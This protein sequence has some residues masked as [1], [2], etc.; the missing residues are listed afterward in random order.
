M[1]ILKVLQTAVWLSK[2]YLSVHSVFVFI[3]V[4][5]CSSMQICVLASDLLYLCLHFIRVIFCFFVNS[6]HLIIVYEFSWRT[7]HGKPFEFVQ[8][9]AGCEQSA[10]RF[11]VAGHY[12]LICS[13]IL[14][15]YQQVKSILGL[16]YT[17]ILKLELRQACSSRWAVGLSVSQRSCSNAGTEKMG[18]D[19]SEPL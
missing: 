18:R 19:G 13:E 7:G 14:A 16:W 10:R 5:W 6:V 2:G 12:L 4:L 8:V 11:L 15:R 3:A 1:T 17:H 9:T